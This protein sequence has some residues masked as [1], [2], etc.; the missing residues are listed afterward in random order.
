MD[1]KNNKTL[2]NQDSEFDLL[3]IIG[4]N[5]DVFVRHPEL[6]DKLKLPDMRGASSLLEL[7]LQRMRDQLAR[8]ESR[9]RSLIHIAKDNQTIVDKLSQV[10]DVLITTKSYDDMLTQLEN[11]FATLFDVC[12]LSCKLKT[13]ENP[14]QYSETVRRITQGRS[15]CDNRFPSQVLNYLFNR[16]V[17]SAA[18]IPLYPSSGSEPIGVLALGSASADRYTQDLGT[19]H[20]DRLGSMVA[21]CINRLNPPATNTL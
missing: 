2:D 18:I 1:T 10:A 8:S 14:E 7:Q 20:L 9:Y 19:A 17:E 11:L 21:Q 16:P 13:S 15:V 5:P 3:E 12:E 6:L 4:S